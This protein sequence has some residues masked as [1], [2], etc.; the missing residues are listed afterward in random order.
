MISFPT[1]WSYVI[2][3]MCDAET[4]AYMIE[5]GTDL[6]GDVLALRDAADT[7]P[8]RVRRYSRSPAS[9]D[10]TTRSS[11]KWVP[12]TASSTGSWMNG[13]SPR[14]S[15]HRSQSEGGP[16]DGIKI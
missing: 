14:C 2:L 7:P 9:L 13:F 5:Q 3:S 10:A 16:Q 1:K 11:S 4:V 15:G 6:H 12:G 8:A